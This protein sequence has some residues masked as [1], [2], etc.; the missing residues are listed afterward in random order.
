MNIQPIVE[1]HG[2]VAAVPVLVRRLRDEAGT[3]DLDVNRPIRRKRSEFVN[4]Q[5]VRK[6]VRLALLQAD[7]AAI[8]M[9]FDADD[10]CP[11][12][13]APK[14]E[15]WAKAEAGTVPCALVMA[16]R[17]YEAW[18]L[19]TVESLRG[20]SGV[21]NDATSH[22]EPES[23]R[24]AK[25]ELEQR[26]HVGLSYAAM[27]DQPAMTAKFDMTT[28]YAR[29]RSFRRMVKAFGEIARGAGVAM[30]NWPPLRWQGA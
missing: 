6:A 30:P 16:N 24:D 4:E 18:F 2:E 25:G 7:C 28:A 20:Q 13:L 14:V 10:D 3:F 1:G 15:A 29:C 26:M 8:L 21:R 12:D 9:I 19:A 5:A 17:E 27:A 23:P 11:K 22:P